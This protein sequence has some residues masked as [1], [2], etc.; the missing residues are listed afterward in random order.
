MEW[1]KTVPGAPTG[2]LS[3]GHNSYRW[4]PLAGTCVSSARSVPVGVQQS[5][6]KSDVEVSTAAPEVPV[7]LCSGA[8]R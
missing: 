6:N 1:R 4:S 3:Q 2:A 8:T 5:W 7:P